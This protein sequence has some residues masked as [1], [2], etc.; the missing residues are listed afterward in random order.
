MPTIMV[1]YGGADKATKARLI[2]ELTRVASEVLDKPTRGFSVII[3][4]TP[5]DN[6][7]I[8]GQTLSEKRAAAKQGPPSI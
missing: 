7:G 2:R 1:Y 8:G 4:D 5:P 6:V 3:H